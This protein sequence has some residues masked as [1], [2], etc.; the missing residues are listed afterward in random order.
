MPLSW[1][2]KKQ[3]TFF[4]VFAGAVFLLVFGIIYL[5][6]SPAPPP[7]PELP[8]AEDLVVFWARFFQIAPGHYEVSAL[9]ENPNLLLGTDRLTYRLRLYD[10]NK[11]FPI[12]KPAGVCGFWR[13]TSRFLPSKTF[14]SR[15]FCWTKTA[16]PSGFQLPK[17]LK[18]PAKGSAR[19][20]SPGAM[21]LTLLPSASKS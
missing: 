19:S 7:A 1:R 12:P 13:K 2:A 17:S 11:I 20:F 21:R 10:Q 5:F 4:A 6:R 16:T 3:L 8:V 9:V 14:F 18:S 15:R